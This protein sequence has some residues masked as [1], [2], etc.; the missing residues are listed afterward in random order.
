MTKEGWSDLSQIARHEAFGDMMHA[1][2]AVDY[3]RKRRLAS[4]DKRGGRAFGVMWVTKVDISNVAKKMV[5]SDYLEQLDRQRL[6]RGNLTSVGS[7]EVVA[8]HGFV[9]ISLSAAEVGSGS[10]RER[11]TSD[12][13]VAGASSPPL[14]SSSSSTRQS[15]GGKSIELLEKLREKM[16]LDRDTEDSEDSEDSNDTEDTEDSERSKET[17]DTMVSED[18]ENIAKVFHEVLESIG[19]EGYDYHIEVHKYPWVRQWWNR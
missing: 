14:P 4:K 11:L 18:A 17:D 19:E 1:M 12:L 16:Q 6:G 8:S 13:L 10:E 15:V 3:E 5:D 2:T 7:Q 9:P